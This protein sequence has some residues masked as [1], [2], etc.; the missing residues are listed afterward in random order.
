MF[1]W[2]RVLVA[3]IGVPLLLF[4]YA[5]ESFFRIN[6]YGLP[7]LIFTNLVIGIGTYEFYKMIKISGKEVYDKFG[8]IV[9]ITIPNLV[10]LSNQSHYSYLDQELKSFSFLSFLIIKFYIDNLYIN[11]RNIVP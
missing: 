7:M 2:N 9:A 4:I 3:L 11:E 5:G 10:Y 1:K 8:I 6:L